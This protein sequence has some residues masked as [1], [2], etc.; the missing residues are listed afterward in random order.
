MIDRQTQLMAVWTLLAVILIVVGVVLFSNKTPSPTTDSGPPASPITA[1]D[2]TFGPLDAKVSIIEYGDFQ[3]P[4]C[5]LYEPVMEQLRS[6]Y[7]STTLFVFRNFPLP[8]HGNALAAAKVAEAAALQGKYWEMV[9]ILYA[10]QKE[11][12]DTSMNSVVTSRFDG[13]AESLG[14]DLKKLHADMESDAVAKKIT[15]DKASG[16]A[17]QITGTP[18]FF[19][20]YAKIENPAGYEPFAAI[21]DKAF[22]APQTT[23]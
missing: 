4:A 21:L 10:K 15:D 1:R 5:G 8:Q 11:W 7:A 19:V 16:T 13:Y 2:H 17:A 20:N 9:G 23:P 3:C 14:L 12:S 22:A 18:T 6:R